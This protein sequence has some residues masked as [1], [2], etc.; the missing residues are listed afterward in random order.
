M[1]NLILELLVMTS[2]AIVVY[3][4]AAAVPRL[5]DK[6]EED[7]GNGRT[8]LPLEKLDNFFLKMKDKL[9]R[10]TKILVMKADNFISKQL[11]SKKL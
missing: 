4:M 1:A 6:D 2:L 9:L 5:E 7:R 3:L 11:K 8:S 10:R